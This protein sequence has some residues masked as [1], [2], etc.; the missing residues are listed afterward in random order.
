MVCSSSGAGPVLAGLAAAAAS[1]FALAVFFASSLAFASFFFVMASA[2]GLEDSDP[3]SP[4]AVVAVLAAAAFAAFI[5]ALILVWSS[6]SFLSY[7]S[8]TF[9]LTRLFLPGRRRPMTPSAS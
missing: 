9:L 3:G 8:K 7:S 2:M 5:C 6:L 1:V 4:V